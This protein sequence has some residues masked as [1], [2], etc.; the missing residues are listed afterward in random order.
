MK[1]KVLQGDKVLWAL[2]AL[3]ALFS[4]FPFLVPVPT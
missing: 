3:L 1:K 2:L 4:F